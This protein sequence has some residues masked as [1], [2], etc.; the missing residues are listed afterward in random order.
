MTKYSKIKWSVWS[1]LT[2]SFVLALFLRMSTGVIAD[3]LSNELRFTSVQISNIA[4]LTLY[5]YAIMQIPA[6]LLIDRFGPRIVTSIGVLIASIGSIIFGLMNSVLLAYLAR[7][8]VGVGTSVI[9]L[10]VFKVQG[11]WF[12]QEEFGSATSK[13][14]FIGNLGSV[15]ATFPLVYLTQ[16]MGWRNS[17]IFI[18][19]IGIVMGISIYII[20]RNTP[21][22]YGFN[23]RNSKEGALVK[24]DLKDG[25]KSVL[26]NK[27]TWYN[28]F[29]MLSLVGISTALASL[30]GIRYIV[31]IY[32]VNK[33]IAAFIIS[34][35]T[36]G[37]VFGS[38]VMD[39]LFKKVKNSKFNIIKIGA[40]INLFIWI[41]IVFVFNMKPP[42]ILLPIMFF[43]IGTINMGHLQAFNDVKYKN[44]ELYSG[45]ATSIINT[46]EFVGSGLINLFIALLIQLNPNNLLIGYKRG[47]M[48]FIVLSM[49]TII[50]ANIG[51]KND[52]DR[53]IALQ[54]NI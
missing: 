45:L 23:V 17:F 35:L 53:F 43:I 51:I 1:V 20:V 10:S 13:F 34:F 28:S 21:I 8:M 52:D 44:K 16:F 11:S 9:I 38:V 27:S 2:V 12:K 25:I 41:S 32:E 22:E 47:F 6:G 50:C 18:G 3:N 46:S 29:I 26:S 54:E 14:C 7:I 48:L 24:I 31:D 15:L 19:V 4:S 36:Y 5:A 37:F 39:L 42:I 30:W 33:S 49:V 40:I